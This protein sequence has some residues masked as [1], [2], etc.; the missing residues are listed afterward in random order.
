MK[1]FFV[2]L[3]ALAKAH[4][5][6]PLSI[7][8][9]CLIL[10]VATLLIYHFP[11][12]NYV[13]DNI[14]SDWNGT[15]IFTTMVVAML[16]V[17]FLFYGLLLYL[18]RIVGR[19]LIALLF[20]GNAISLYF[21][22]TYKVLITSDMMGNVFNTRFSE[23]SGFFS[24][25]AV[26]YVIFLGLLP[27]A[28]V[29]LRKVNYGSFRRF[30]LSTVL[31]IM[32]IAGVAAAN[33][34]NILWIDYHA[35]CIGSLI[36]PWS[37]TVNTGRYFYQQYLLNRDEILLPDATITTEDREV[38]VLVIGESARRDHF[39][40]YGYSRQTNPLLERDSVTT[41][42]AE[43][44]ATFTTDGVKAI[45]DHK[46]TD[47]LYE[48]LPNYLHRMGVDVV[49]RSTNWGEPPLHIEKEYNHSALKSRY[50]DANGK[51]DGILL[52]DL[53]EEIEACESNK[54]LIVLHTSTSHGP[55]YYDKYPSEFK[56]FTPVCTTVEMSKADRKELNNAYD[57]TI[58]YTDYLLHSVIEVLREI[59]D[60]RSTM[61]YISDHGESLGEDNLY[62][63]GLPM[64]IAPKEQ[65]NIPFIVWC[66]DREQKI[67]PLSKVGHY[68]V[69]HS[70]L[71]FLHI[72]SPIYNESHNIF[73]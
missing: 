26:M 5:A 50:P 71:N 1:E 21:I 30:L 22:N 57:N 40:L 45:V 34:S 69:F 7:T 2:N 72:D 11:F 65:L 16:A 44:S 17:N 37:Y 33:L 43:A 8:W 28:Y 12:F 46:A 39:S 19:G 63:H 51:Y 27:A 73:K 59:D 24:T 64:M 10:S 13:T 58:L 60:A 29:I 67:K 48:I 70:V 25:S 23:A 61:I 9:F 31:S 14:E 62:M 32:A 6:K 52:E 47:D 15:L 18:C 49:W 20:V 53:K 38:V 35:T 68:H 42:V 3:Y 66:S 54:V 56:K 55:E 41:L 36:M 4:F